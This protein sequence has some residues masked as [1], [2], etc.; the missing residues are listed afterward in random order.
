MITIPRDVQNP[1]RKIH[2]ESSLGNEIYGFKSTHYSNYKRQNTHMK[3][4]NVNPFQKQACI[5]K[6]QEHHTLPLVS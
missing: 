2:R 1:G 6:C 3:L 5:N 4:I